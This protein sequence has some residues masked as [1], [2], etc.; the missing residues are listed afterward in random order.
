MEPLQQLRRNLLERFSN[1]VEQGDRSDYFEFFDMKD[2][3]GIGSH[4]FKIRTKRGVLKKGSNIEME[5]L[6]EGGLPIPITV[7]SESS[8]FEER[9]LPSHRLSFT[10]TS[11]TISGIATFVAFGTAIDGKTVKYIRRILIDKGTQVKPI[12]DRGL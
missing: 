6:D 5:L 4:V 3:Y 8:T 11:N 7:A 9:F 10:V 1:I 12:I 2:T